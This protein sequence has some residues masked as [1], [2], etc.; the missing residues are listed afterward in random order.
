MPWKRHINWPIWHIPVSYDLAKCSICGCLLLSS[1]FLP[2]YP[3]ATVGWN[4]LL[5]LAPIDHKIDHS[6]FREGSHCGYIVLYSNRKFVSTLW[7]ASRWNWM[8]SRLERK[9]IGRWKIGGANLSEV[10]ECQPFSCMFAERC[11]RDLDPC[12]SYTS[13]CKWIKIFHL[14]IVSKF[15]RVWVFYLYCTGVC[16]FNFYRIE[17]SLAGKNTKNN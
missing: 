10:R 14:L 9:L 3:F 11:L 16:T 2:H 1:L 6:T 7:V 4:S 5:T 8:C 17:A 12:I 13:A 15:A